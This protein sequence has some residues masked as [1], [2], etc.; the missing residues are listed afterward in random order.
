MI[1]S[2]YCLSLLRCH[3]R[4]PAVAIRAEDTLAEPGGDDTETN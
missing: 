2:Y 4:V 3:D 1:E